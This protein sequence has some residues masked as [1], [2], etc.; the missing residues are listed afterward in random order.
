MAVVI[1]EEFKLLCKGAVRLQ[2]EGSGSEVAQT[3]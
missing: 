3:I 2:I 1:R